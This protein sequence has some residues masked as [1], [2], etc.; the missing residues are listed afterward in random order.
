M[1]NIKTQYDVVVIG[2][3]HNGL[4]SAC[5]LAKA[6]FSVLMLERNTEIGGATRSMQVF[7]GMDARLSAYSYL[8]SLFPQKIIDDLGMRLRLKTRKTASWTPA[9]EKG[10]FRELLLRNGDPEFNR[11][12]F[13]KLT[14][15]KNDYR[16]F[17]Q[18]QNMQ[19][20][21]ASVIWPSLTSPL[22]SRKQLRSRLDLGADKAW[23]AL[24][25][26]PIGNAIERLISDDLI[27]GIVFTDGRIGVSTFPH[28]PTLIQNRC[29]LYHVIG[30]GTGEWKVPLGGMGSLVEDLVA[31]AKQSGL[32]TFANRAK[33]LR[34]DPG[35]K[36]SSISFDQ[37]GKTHEV[38]A[39]FILCN[40][41]RQVLEKLL[42][43]SIADKPV[44]EGAGF[45]MN[46]LL[47]RLPKLRSKRFEASEAFAGTVHID[48]G[49]EQMMTSYRESNSGKVPAKP[50]GEIYCH[51]LTD[52]SILSDELVEQGYHTLTLF[53]LDLPYSLFEKD[54]EK[55]RAEASA[56]YLAGIN[57]YLD[58]P[59]EACLATDANGSPCIEAM[60]ALDLENKLRLPKGNIFH[61]DLTWPFAD[62]DED[63]GQWGVETEYSNILICGSAAKRGGA[64]SGIP[65]HN[66]A[67][68]VLDMANSMKS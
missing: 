61:G 29:F 67:M 41:S 43:E 35:I 5:Y 26:E 54:N 11:D 55:V 65:G 36:R 9:L 47:K 52:T 56:K 2:S 42:D 15:N 46:L 3:G 12:A 20:E 40:A 53:G 60:S 18:L 38:D 57:Q 39:R 16:G 6:G 14:G 28:D 4:V 59:I 66:A 49:Y 45:K 19:E 22:L 68:K 13:I 33:A 23:Q 50:P 17:L 63:V 37:D 1:T 34:I 44:I 31:I 7:P 10:T 27:R 48:E 62:S 32:V 21:L 58:E 51:T 24:I 25:E 8:V 30:Q 64:V